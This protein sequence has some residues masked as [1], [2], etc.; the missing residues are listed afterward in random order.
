MYDDAL[1]GER[2]LSKKVDEFGE[3][4]ELAYEDLMFPQFIGEKG[5]IWTGK[6]A[7]ST[8]FPEGN[9]KIASDRIVIKYAQHVTSSI[10]NLKSEF[11]NSKLD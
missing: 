4:N 3:S 1:E 5:S 7:K 10:L 8:E 2:D 6:N 9:C 11:H